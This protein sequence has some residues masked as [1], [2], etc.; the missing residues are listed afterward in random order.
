MSPTRIPGR[1][2][3]LRRS[4]LLNS[5]KRPVFVVTDIIPAG[6]EE[7]VS[8]SRTITWSPEYNSERKNVDSETGPVVSG[9]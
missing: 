4:V 9:T 2:Q 1:R 5:A 6:I 7:Q 3:S 8:F